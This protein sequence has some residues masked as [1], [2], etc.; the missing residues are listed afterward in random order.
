MIISLLLKKIKYLSKEY[1][2]IYKSVGSN[3]IDLKVKNK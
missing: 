2:A 1:K 3:I